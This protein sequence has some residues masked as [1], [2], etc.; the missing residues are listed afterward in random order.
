MVPV[1]YK[2]IT[3]IVD[4]I[5]P[6]VQARGRVLTKD[7]LLPRKRPHAT[8]GAEG[9]PTGATRWTAPSGTPLLWP[10][11]QPAGQLLTDHHFWRE[12]MPEG[13]M[14]LRR[15]LTNSTEDQGSALDICVSA[16]DLIRGVPNE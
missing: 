7:F 8:T 1:E 3:T 2:G 14:C 15:L 5:R 10:N 11:A 12:D 9:P 6:C 16:A 13:L 4:V